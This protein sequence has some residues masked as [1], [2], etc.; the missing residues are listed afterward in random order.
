MKLE[1]IKIGRIVNAHGIRGEVRVQP[2]DADPFFLT[3]F[4]TFYLDGQPVKPTA[5][6]VHKSLVLMKLPGVGQK[7][8]GVVLL[9]AFGE[10]QFPVDTHVFRVSNR[11]G[12]AE[13]DDV[14]KT[15]LQ[16]Q[17]AIPKQDWLDM[18]HRIIF[19]GRRVC[20]AQRPLCAEC[21]MRDM[22]KA[23]RERQKATK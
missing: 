5:C 14:L 6:H 12:L 4:K 20:K 21:T 19:H 18:H 16:L 3:Q 22:C 2:R 15:E 1:M 23:E 7:T 13:A 11:L 17:K 10:A 8:A 9:A